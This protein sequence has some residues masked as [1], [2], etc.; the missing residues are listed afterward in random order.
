G[1]LP[2]WFTLFRHRWDMSLALMSFIGR[3]IHA[4]PICFPTWPGSQY[5]LLNLNL[6]AMTIPLAMLVATRVV[7]AHDFLKCTRF[8]MPLPRT[9]SRIAP[10]SSH[11][12][13]LL[14][15]S[16]K[17]GRISELRREVFAKAL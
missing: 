9:R 10:S 16:R 1:H 5:V 13:R 14:L 4:L 6:T 2:A 12:T 15:V 3:V 7:S 17:A 11:K 8:P